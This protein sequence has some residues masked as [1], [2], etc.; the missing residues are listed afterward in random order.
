MNMYIMSHV[1]ESFQD[2]SRI[3]DFEAADFRQ[4]LIASLIYFQ[5]ILGQLTI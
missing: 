5:F 3:Q 4:I 1:H 2:Y